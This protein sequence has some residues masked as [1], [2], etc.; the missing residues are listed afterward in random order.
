MDDIRMRQQM[1]FIVE[2]QAQFT[3]D[4]VE[5]KSETAEL[6]G[7]VTDLAKAVTRLEAQAESDRAETREAINNLIIANEVTRK[8][9]EDVARL[10]MQTSH[11]VTWLESN[12]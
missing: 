6:K 10:A 8:L 2:Q 9:T 1:E 7:I 5:L 3:L 4:M 11:R 12:Q